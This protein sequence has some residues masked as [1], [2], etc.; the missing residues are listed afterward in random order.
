MHVANVLRVAANT[1][2]LLAHG[3]D[4]RQQ[5]ADA[6]VVGERRLCHKRAFASGALGLEEFHAV[7][8]QAVILAFKVKPV[9]ATI[10]ASRALVIL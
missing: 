9:R 4:N 7:A 6:D 2:V 3:A 8:G 1:N 10:R 5:G